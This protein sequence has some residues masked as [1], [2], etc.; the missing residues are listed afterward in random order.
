M[1]RDAF[2]IVELK[3]V[4]TVESIVLR[5]HVLYRRRCYNPIV[6]RSKITIFL[7]LYQANDASAV[8]CRPPIHRLHSI[9]TGQITNCWSNQHFSFLDF[10][11]LFLFQWNFYSLWFL[12]FNFNSRLTKLLF[13]TNVSN[14]RP[15][16]DSMPSNTNV[17]GIGRMS[18]NLYTTVCN[19][20][21]VFV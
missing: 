19:H 1:C 5:D 13:I 10:Y 15:T 4:M 2:V 11:N 21:I 17:M 3:L 18:R 12:V 16:V 8:F 14:A 6:L 20:C 7:M 9:T